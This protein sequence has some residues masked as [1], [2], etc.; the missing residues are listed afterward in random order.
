MTWLENTPFP[1][2]RSSTASSTDRIIW[3][4]S[5]KHTVNN[6]SAHVRHHFALYQLTPI[7]TL[8][9]TFSVC[10]LF[11]F[12]FPQF[13]RI[14][15][16]AP[17]TKQTTVRCHRCSGLAE[18]VGRPSCSHGPSSSPHVSRPLL[19]Y[20]W[21]RRWISTSSGGSDP[22]AGMSGEGENFPCRVN[23]LSHY[24]FQWLSQSHTAE[25][26]ACTKMTK[27]KMWAI[28]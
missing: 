18:G 28:L 1:T 9:K 15:V 12:S 5:K 25:G 3:I 10:V 20:P 6:N 2:A 26:H 13:L 16:S 21:A 22:A 17:G 23:K 7:T 11:I 19:M 8:L 14:L 24:V 27:L 4:Q